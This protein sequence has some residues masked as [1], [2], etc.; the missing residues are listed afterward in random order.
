[1]SRSLRP[2]RRRATSRSGER[3]NAVVLNRILR[4]QAGTDAGGGSAVA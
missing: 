4:V 3:W 2:G 1:M